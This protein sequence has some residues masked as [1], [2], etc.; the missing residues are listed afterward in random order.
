M[1]KNYFC[2]RFLGDPAIKGG[3]KCV[4]IKW[5][6]PNDLDHVLRLCVLNRMQHTAG[7]TKNQI[8]PL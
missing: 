3:R 2:V 7:V 4:N 6:F 8:N 5:I 1:D